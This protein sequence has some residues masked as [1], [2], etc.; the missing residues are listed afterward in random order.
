LIIDKFQD[1]L[2]IRLESFWHYLTQEQGDLAGILDKETFYPHE[3]TKK[4]TRNFLS[5]LFD[6][7][8]QAKRI[9]KYETIGDRKH[10][11]TEY[12][13]DYKIIQKLVQKYNVEIPIDS[14][15]LSGEGGTSGELLGNHVDDV[16]H[17][18]TYISTC[19]EIDGRC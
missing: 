15:I 5:K 13:F 4:V 3:F 10:Q 6:E 14:V 17:L 7:K 12:L 8:F 11:R 18:K 19:A 16:D 9:T 2:S 1:T